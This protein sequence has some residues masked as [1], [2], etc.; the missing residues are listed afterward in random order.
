MTK[1]ADRI[2]DEFL[3]WDIAICS[4]LIAL[5]FW[6]GP[7]RR[8]QGLRAAGRG[9]FR[10]RK[11]SYTEVYAEHASSLLVWLERKIGKPFEK[12]YFFNIFLLTGIP[13]FLVI[14]ATSWRL[15]TYDQ[16]FIAEFVIKYNYGILDNILTIVI[17]TSFIYLTCILSYA[18]TFYL[19]EQMQ[20]I[21]Y[22]KENRKSNL[23][24]RSNELVGKILKH[25]TMALATI[26]TLD[27][28]LSYVLT[29]GFLTIMWYV[30]S[31]PVNGCTWIDPNERIVNGFIHLLTGEDVGPKIQPETFIWL[32]LSALPTLLHLLVSM[33][34]LFGKVFSNFL[35]SFVAVLLLRM[36]QGKNGVLKQLAIIL[37][38]TAKLVQELSKGIV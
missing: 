21:S 32:L 35:K 18:I 31:C 33:L 38:A 24:T 12:R 29:T 3:I 4:V 30:S 9:F 15:R 25:P 22:S 8:K 26:V 27:I 1:L 36:S 5:D 10:L 6:L 19:L 11:L 37:G 13:S 20:H 34:F 16:E 23:N 7:K 28:V 14:T 2:I 17:V